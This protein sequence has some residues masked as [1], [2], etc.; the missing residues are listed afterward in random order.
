MTGCLTDS[1]T[2]KEPD[3][4]KKNWAGFMLRVETSRNQP[5]IK[6]QLWPFH[7]STINYKNWRHLLFTSP[8]S[9]FCVFG[10]PHFNL[11]RPWTESSHSF[12]FFFFSGGGGTSVNTPRISWEELP[13]L[14][15]NF[16]SLTGSLPKFSPLQELMSVSSLTKVWLTTFQSEE[17]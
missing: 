17:I 7:L 15:I 6:M 10:A 13:F 3:E 1:E 5:L 4:N 11:F 9:Q 2:N 12:F 8:V 14:F 16:S